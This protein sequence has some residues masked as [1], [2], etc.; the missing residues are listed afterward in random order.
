MNAY[1]TPP[2]ASSVDQKM[3]TM[4]TSRIWISAFWFFGSGRAPLLWW[5]ALLDRR[6]SAPHADI[7]REAPRILIGIA[8]AAT[9]TQIVSAS[10][11]SSAACVGL[12]YSASAPASRLL[13]P[14][15]ANQHPPFGFLD[16]LRLS[17]FNHG[18]S[19]PHSDDLHR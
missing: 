6:P 4:K 1:S 2:A 10:G 7:A 9:A 5:A 3:S 14:D 15:R 19:G 17:R 16:A 11:S 12:P 18:R 13:S 8:T